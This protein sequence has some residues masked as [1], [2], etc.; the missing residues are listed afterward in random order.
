MIIATLIELTI[1]GFIIS[2]GKDVG[3]CALK[4]MNYIIPYHFT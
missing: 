4:S 1:N 2:I 3:K